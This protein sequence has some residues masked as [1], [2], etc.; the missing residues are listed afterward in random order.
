MLTRDL[1]RLVPAT[2]SNRFYEEDIYYDSEL[3]L[4]KDSSSSVV[5]PEDRLTD[6]IRVSV[7]ATLAVFPSQTS[8]QD[9]VL[10]NNSKA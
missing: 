6:W 4:A 3:S 9:K 10:F 2:D 1:L 8:C 5:L 7:R